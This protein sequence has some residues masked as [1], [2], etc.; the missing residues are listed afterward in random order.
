MTKYRLCRFRVSLTDGN[1]LADLGS[2]ASDVY[3]QYC[4]PRLTRNN[5]YELKGPGF[6][7][8]DWTSSL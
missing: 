6:E 5:Q 1:R 3:Q 8:I 2:G 7:Y 4:L